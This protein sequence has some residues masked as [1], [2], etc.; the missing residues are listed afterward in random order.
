MN[1]RNHNVKMN[2][3]NCLN[4]QLSKQYM[5][6]FLLF[7]NFSSLYTCNLKEDRLCWR[8]FPTSPLQCCCSGI[9]GWYLMQH[10]QRCVDSHSCFTLHRAQREGTFIAWS[11]TCNTFKDILWSGAQFQDPRPSS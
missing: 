11:Q 3:K 10:E 9:A 4:F 5:Y 7:I 2:G 1:V 6:L 8:I